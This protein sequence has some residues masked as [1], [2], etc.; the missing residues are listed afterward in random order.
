MSASK[1]AVRSAPAALDGYGPA[2]T[3]AARW[4]ISSAGGLQRSVDQGNTWQDVSVN[5]APG[6]SA[7]ALTFESSAPV[8]AARGKAAD[9]AADKDAKADKLNAPITFRAV[10]A[11]GADVWAGGSAGLLYH[12]ADAGAHWTRVVPSTSSAV[13]T[14]DIIS[15]EFLDAQHGKVSTSTSEI[16]TTSDAGQTWQKQP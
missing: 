1:S 5:A 4:T 2:T 6:Y 7:G 13:L 3:L 9:K 8:P 15:L 10:A 12:S 16:W 11:S 14:G